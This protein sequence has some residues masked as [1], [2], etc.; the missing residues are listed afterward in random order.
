M[1]N[2]TLQKPV[3]YAALILTLFSTLFYLIASSPETTTFAAL[4]NSFILIVVGIFRTI[5]W[6]I[7]MLIALMACL[8]FLFAI[9]LGA[10]SLFDRKVA[11]HMYQGLKKNLLNAL[12]PGQCCT[13]ASAQ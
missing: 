8:T 9:F 3:V 13:C 2:N 1:I 5:Q 7:A 4:Q 10:V 11:V 6:L 12:L